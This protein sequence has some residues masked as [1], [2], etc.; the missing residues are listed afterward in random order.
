MHIPYADV[1][2][3]AKKWLRMVSWL[4][5]SPLVQLQEEDG[6]YKA[7]IG[8]Y[9]WYIPYPKPWMALWARDFMAT[10][11]RFEA[12]V[13]PG[14]IVIEVGACTGEYT[15]PIARRVGP[16]GRVYAFEADPRSYACLTKNIALSEVATAVTVEHL[17]V[18]DTDGASLVLYQHPN[19]IAHGSLH[20]ASSA[21]VTVQT[22]TLDSYFSNNAD[23][24]QAALLKLTVNGHE[25]EILRGAVGLLQHIPYVTLQSA[26]HQ[27]AIK[28]LQ[29]YGFQVQAEHTLPQDYRAVLL[30]KSAACHPAMQID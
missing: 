11:F 23:G 9:R 6:V 2:A 15:I 7:R 30:K 21:A 4:L 22:V 5:K 13:T 14:D 29:H 28:F 3:Q 10:H 24:H 1:F 18:S 17:A 19:T 26:R 25:P 12:V 16:R 27:E 20:R 8:R